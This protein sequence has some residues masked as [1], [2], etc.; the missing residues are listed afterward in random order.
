MSKNW[1]D[2]TAMQLAFDVSTE[3]Q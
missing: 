3:L 1:N 2:V